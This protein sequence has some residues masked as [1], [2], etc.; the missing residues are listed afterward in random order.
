MATL[1]LEVPNGLHH[2]LL[3][4]AENQ[5]VDLNAYLLYSLTQLAEKD[6][7]IVFLSREEIAAQERNIAQ[8]KAGLEPA[9]PDQFGAALE[10]GEESE[11]E[12]ELTPDLLAAIE[13][14]IAQAKQRKAMTIPLHKTHPVKM[15]KTTPVLQE[16]VSAGL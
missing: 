1:S 2:K 3:L 5:G 4:A 15:G 7:A 8:I 13:E 16:L 10:W 12:P 11:P 14:K 9:T 6:S